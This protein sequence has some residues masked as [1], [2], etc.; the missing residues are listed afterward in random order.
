[1]YVAIVARYFAKHCMAITN[2]K[3]SKSGIGIGKGF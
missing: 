2:N 3:V 1:M